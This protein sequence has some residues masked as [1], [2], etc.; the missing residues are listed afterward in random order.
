M[1]TKVS[2][3]PQV[4]HFYYFGTFNSFNITNFITAK[5]VI[6]QNV[7]ENFT[8]SQMNATVNYDFEYIGK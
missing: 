5:T 3:R 1:A 7:Y 4:E 2:M 8:V 6:M